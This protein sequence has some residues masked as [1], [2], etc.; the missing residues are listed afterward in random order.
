[1]GCQKCEWWF[2]RA[3]TGDNEWFTWKG[4]KYNIDIAKEITSNREPSLVKTSELSDYVSYIS[5]G[6]GIDEDYNM[7]GVS[8]YPEHADHVVSD[9]VQHIIMAAVP[10][11]GHFPIDG[12]HRIV[13][14]MMLRQK[15]CHCVFLDAAET[16]R[17]R[18][19]LH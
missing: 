6:T 15:F 9:G 5:P 16:M 11:G 2:N 1:M 4:Q 8:V 3:T 17:I 18:S 19:D 12:H 14:A 7:F 10:G 13:R